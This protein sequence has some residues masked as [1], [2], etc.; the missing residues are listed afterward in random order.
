MAGSCRRQMG[1][2]QAARDAR[3]TWATQ[4]GSGHGAI[5]AIDRGEVAAF[6]GRHGVRRLAV[7][8]SALGDD[9]GPASALDLLV[10][11]APTT[12]VSLLDMVALEH[13]LTRIVG[14]AV[15]LRTPEDLS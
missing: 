13:E 10:D 7:F 14:R 6:C 9:F 15:D 8:G 1:Q 11:F 12:R 4:R 5:P 2:R 3:C